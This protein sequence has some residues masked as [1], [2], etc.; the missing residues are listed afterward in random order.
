MVNETNIQQRRKNRDKVRES[1]REL[2]PCPHDNKE[3]IIDYAQL[4]KEMGRY[5]DGLD[6]LNPVIRSGELGPENWKAY[7]LAAFF[8]LQ[9]GESSLCRN[10]M[11][12]A[13]KC[14]Q[15]DRRFFNCMRSSQ[16]YNHFAYHYDVQLLSDIDDF[17]NKRLFRRVFLQEITIGSEG[18]IYISE[19]L[20]R[21]VVAL[22]NMGNFLWGKS[23][24]LAR[25]QENTNSLDEIILMST[26]SGDGLTI[27]D[28]SN[29]DMIQMDRDGCFK[30]M[31]P[32]GNR[33]FK[34]HSFTQDYFGSIFVT[35]DN[36]MRLSI[37]ESDGKLQREIFL[38]DVMHYNTDIN[39]FT[40][41]YDEEGFLHLYNIDV[42]LTLNGEG[43]K[44]FRKDFITENKAKRDWKEIVKGVSPDQAG[45]LYVVRPS[46]NR[47]VVVDKNMGTELGQLGPEVGNTRLRHPTDVATDFDDNLYIS[48]TGNARV[49]KIN[50][51][52]GE[53]TAIFQFPHWKSSL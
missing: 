11:M 47:I 15:T 22:D 28:N 48:D 10:L 29:G 3:G 24:N 32:L 23:L 17:L 2:P 8:N 4:C 9:R 39:P 12:N 1:C 19:A 45:R 46:E 44:I 14:L 40:I 6:V 30:T 5:D 27:V 50:G 37:F 35:E 20:G 7:A 42:L 26:G 16:T 53:V 38:D 18:I 13:C 33:Y 51:S 43:R 25:K 34:V 36:P 31:A 21:K 49:L 52:N 41:L